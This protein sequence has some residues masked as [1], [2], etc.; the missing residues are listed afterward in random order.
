MRACVRGDGEP[1]ETRESR[2][3]EQFTDCGPSAL[4]ESGVTSRHGRVRRTGGM[5]SI[6]LPATTGHSL[7]Q[8]QN[9]KRFFSPSSRSLPGSQYHRLDHTRPMET[10]S[11]LLYS[12]GD[13]CD[14]SSSLSTIVVGTHGSL[15]PKTH[16]KPTK[17]AKKTSPL[18]KSGAKPRTGIRTHRGART[19]PPATAR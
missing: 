10:L 4:R 5:R 12:C 1:P 14:S 8:V 3:N 6:H 19:P 13:S 16:E 2:R 9:S 7:R 11:A 17:N 15:W 18:T